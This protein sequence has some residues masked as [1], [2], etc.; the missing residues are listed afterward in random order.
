MININDINLNLPV[1]CKIEL[2][3]PLLEI[4]KIEEYFFFLYALHSLRIQKAYY[5]DYYS[6]AQFL[7]IDEMD[8]KRAIK[9]MYSHN[10]LSR[11]ENDHV[12]I[13]KSIL[14][15][16]EIQNDKRIKEYNDKLFEKS[17]TEKFFNRSKAFDPTEEEL[18]SAGKDNY[19]IKIGEDIN[20]AIKIQ[21]PIN[22]KTPLPLI[23]SPMRLPIISTL[24]NEITHKE[25]LIFGVIIDQYPFG[26]DSLKFDA[27][28]NNLNIPVS[29]VK[30]SIQKLKNKNL[31]TP[32]FN[33]KT[34]ENQLNISQDN[35]ETLLEYIEDEADNQIFIKKNSK[36]QKTTSS[37]L[38]QHV[39]QSYYRNIPKSTNRPT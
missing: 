31:I 35:F 33:P 39:P 16:F 30:N 36:S 38:L 6:I 26:F 10:L 7:K 19:E 23:P 15:A 20:S 2:I 37:L 34:R 18:I 12:I 13:N 14:A 24:L 28:G 8:I 25:Y 21:T 1:V 22:L 3:R 9:K 27:I 32:S 5:K 29:Y 4:F 11:D 17:S